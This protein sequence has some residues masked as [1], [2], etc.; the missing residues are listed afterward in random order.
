MWSDLPFPVCC[1]HIKS[2]FVLYR[3]KLDCLKLRKHKMQNRIKLLYFLSRAS[4][5]HFNHTSIIFFSEN[6]WSYLFGRV[7]GKSFWVEVC[8]NIFMQTWTGLL[9]SSL[10]KHCCYGFSPDFSFKIHASEY[11]RKAVLLAISQHMLFVA[12]SILHVVDVLF[13]PRRCL[14]LVVVVLVKMIK[15]RTSQMVVSCAEGSRHVWI[16]ALPPGG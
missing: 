8:L 9:F 14:V 5:H 12:G 4:V 7:Q 13:S 1:R 6:T 2:V 15:I 11:R 3:R 16:K 10:P